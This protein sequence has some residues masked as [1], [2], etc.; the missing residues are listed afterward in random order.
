MHKIQ[1][2]CVDIFK[3]KFDIAFDQKRHLTIDNQESKFSKLIQS[4][5]DINNILFCYGSNWWV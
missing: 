5:A 3:L 4:V 1:N 2:G